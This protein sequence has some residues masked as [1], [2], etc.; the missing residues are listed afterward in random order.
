VALLSETAKFMTSL[1][2][3]IFIIL[4][5]VISI[6]G[7][8]QGWKI[9]SY[10][11][12]YRLFEYNAVGNNPT[13]IGPLLKEPVAYQRYLSTITNNSLYGNP[14]TVRQHTFYMNAE[15]GK[16]NALLRLWKKYTIQAGLLLTTRIRQ[17]IGAIGEE[18]FSSSS[19]TVI[20]KNM[21][22]LAKNQQFLGANAGVNR[23]FSIFKRW[24]FL[25]GLHA[26][27]SFAMLHYYQQRWDSSIFT[28][29]GEWSTRTTQLPD[30]KGK[31]FFQWQVMVPLGFEYE[32]QKDRA[33][34][35][36]EVDAGIIGSHYRPKNSTSK[37]AHGA[38]IWLLY[39]PG[40]KR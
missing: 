13:T 6:G 21:Y 5:S 37:E 38:G 3:A 29:S 8:A 40:K 14:E 25:I 11:V 32:I 16:E 4:L 23:R 19:D 12:G 17:D 2:A 30:L 28:R 24:K 27:G 26:Q 10:N 22:A 15:W 7:K 20:R 36:F 33:F 34:I 18:S 9:I 39:V 35:R 31:N 1:K